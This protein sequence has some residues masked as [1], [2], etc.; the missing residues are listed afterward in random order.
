MGTNILEVSSFEYIKYEAQA[1]LS[2][3]AEKELLS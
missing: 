2:A 3:A 1:L